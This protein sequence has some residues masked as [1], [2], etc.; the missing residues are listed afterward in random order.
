[1]CAMDPIVVISD[2]DPDV[3]RFGLDPLQNCIAGRGISCAVRL[4]MLLGWAVR[5][6]KSRY[7]CMELSRGKVTINFC[8]CTMNG[9]SHTRKQNNWPRIL[10][11]YTFLSCAVATRMRSMRS[12]HFGH[13]FKR[14][15]ESWKRA[16]YWR[17]VIDPVSPSVSVLYYS[18]I[19]SCPFW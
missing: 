14:H 12:I 4:L 16:H 11:L 18:L 7:V 5:R 2:A 9:Q 6:V 17:P 3:P 15:K 19:F 1:M 10:C 8:S 13:Q